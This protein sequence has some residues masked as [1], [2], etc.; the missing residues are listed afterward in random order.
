[1]PGGAS[2]PVR[3]FIPL[4]GLQQGGPKLG[5]AGAERRLG[6]DRIIARTRGAY[7]M[8]SYHIARKGGRLMPGRTPHPVPDMGAKPRRL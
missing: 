5:Q 8:A 4:V 2:H 3:V 7:A 6:G 1:M